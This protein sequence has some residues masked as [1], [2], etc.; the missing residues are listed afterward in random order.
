[1]AGTR[2]ELE[3]WQ[4]PTVAPLVE[5][6]GVTKT[7]GSHYAIDDVSLAIYPGEFFSLLG[8]SGCGKTTLLR[9]LAGFERP[10][11]GRLRIGGEDVT[12]LPP[13]RR[14]VNMMFQSYALFPH[15]TVAQNVAIP[16]REYLD[17]PEG[18]IDALAKLKIEIVGLKMADF[19]KLPSELSG[20][21][22][23]RAAIARALALDQRGQPP[24]RR[25][26]GVIVSRMGSDQHPRSVA[27]NRRRHLRAPIVLAAHYVHE[28]DAWGAPLHA[29]LQPPDDLQYVLESATLPIRVSYAVAGHEDHLA[30]RGGLFRTGEDSEPAAHVEDLEFENVELTQRS[31]K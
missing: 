16:I 12:D 31:Y 11:Q 30:V 9:M 5:I 23:K 29:L 3:A 24:A 7:F 28:H 14:P 17:L 21:M 8:A 27:A 10:N 25:V 15:M 2:P 18:L 19:D 26:I 13:Y 20:G 22:I 1:M 6:Q 4:D